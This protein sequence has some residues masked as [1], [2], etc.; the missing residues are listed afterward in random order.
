MSSRH[1]LPFRGARSASE[2]VSRAP[3]EMPEDPLSAIFDAR[4]AAQ[5]LYDPRF[6]H[7]ACGVAFVANMQRRADPRH[8][9]PGPHRPAQ[10]RAPR[11]H[12][13]RAGHRRRRRHP[14]PGAR[15]A[16]C[17]RSSTFDLPA[18]GHY[19]VGIAFLPDRRR[20][21]AAGA[22][23]PIEK[24][25]AEEGLTVLGWRDV[26]D[27]RLDCVGATAR[28]VMPTFRQLFV[29][30]PA[31]A[32]GHRPRP[33]RPSRCASAP[34]TRRERL[35]PVAV[36]AHLVYKGMLTTPQLEPFFPD[37]P[38]ER[39][40]SA[41]ALVHSRFSTNTFPSWPLAH[42]YRL[43]RPQRRDQHGPGQPQLDAGPRGAC[44]PAT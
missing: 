28:G 42:P 20:P 15:R 32:A 6:E 25:A 38:D 21:R 7:D 18:A 29:A 19:A 13:R 3:L 26:P 35:L 4:P 36:G 8:R 39:V 31:G 17:A 34:S 41:L 1:T 23:R 16:S 14:A 11:R 33:A 43:H 9:R 40:E 12:R 2:P 44:S 24:I 27:R 30:D 5:G 22:A 10:P 37:L